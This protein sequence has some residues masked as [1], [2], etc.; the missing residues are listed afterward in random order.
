M[1]RLVQGDV[2]SGKTMVAAAA[3]Y[4]VINAGYQAALM[5]P[6]FFMLWL[7]VGM[8]IFFLGAQLSRFRQKERQMRPFGKKTV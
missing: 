4:A 1:N 8:Y 2:G 5:A 3:I 7:Y 6:I